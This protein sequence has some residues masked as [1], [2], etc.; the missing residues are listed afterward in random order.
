MVYRRPYLYEI[1]S[2][3]RLECG[4]YRF[5]EQDIKYR[6]FYTPMYRITCLGGRSVEKIRYTVINAEA[7]SYSSGHEIVRNYTRRCVFNFTTIAFIAIP[8]K[9]LRAMN[10]IEW[11]SRSWMISNFKLL[12]IGERC[13]YVD[14]YIFFDIDP[15]GKKLLTKFLQANDKLKLYQWWRRSGDF[16]AWYLYALIPLSWSKGKLSIENPS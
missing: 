4:I 3:S 9:V 8:V 6:V 16:N 15:D 5:I 13:V 1:D 11:C 2:T 7:G 12:N 10:Y 14:V